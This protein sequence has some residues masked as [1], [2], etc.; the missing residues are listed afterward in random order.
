MLAGASD[1][2]QAALF[3]AN[4]AKRVTMQPRVNEIV[5]DKALLRHLQTEII[6][7]R[8][9]LVSVMSP[10]PLPSNCPLIHA[11]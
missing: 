3:F 10:R 5:R 9:Q 2:T 7:L 1:N 4:A 6:S 11:Q 8:K